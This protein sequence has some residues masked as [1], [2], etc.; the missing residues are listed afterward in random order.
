M[1]VAF[2]EGHGASGLVKEGKPPEAPYERALEAM[3]KDLR[4]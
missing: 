1:I 3:L 2:L 4:M